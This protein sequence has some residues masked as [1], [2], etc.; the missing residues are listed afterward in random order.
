M[1]EVQSEVAKHKKAATSLPQRLLAKNQAREAQ[2]KIA[3]AEE[4]VA[5][6]K[7]LTDKLEGGEVKEEDLKAA[8]AAIAEEQES[9]VGLHKFFEMQERKMVAG[10]VDEEMQTAIDRAKALKE[11]FE[12]AKAT[13]K[14]HADA[15]VVT[16]LRKESE[17][18]VK[19]V[20]D[21]V[22]KAAD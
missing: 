21:A 14:T 1:N 3:T 13:V 7:E 8:E 20:E 15:I 22:E 6:V 5:K 2:G 18:K 19:A 4:N 12:A 16:A 9:I 11:A 10:N 17:E